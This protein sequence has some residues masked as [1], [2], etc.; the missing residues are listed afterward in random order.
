MA[1]SIF[2]Q[3][4][5]NNREKPAWHGLGI[6]D[7]N[8]HYAPELVAKFGSPEILK[9]P[10]MVTLPNGTVEATPYHSL[11]RAP[12]PDDNRWL[13]FGT[14]VSAD[15]EVFNATIAAR[16][17]DQYVRDTRG[18]RVPVETVALLQM[19]TR[20]FITV[21]LPTVDVRGD[22]VE[23][24]L[25]LDVPFG[26][27]ETIGCYVTPVRVVCMNTLRMG[28]A[29][30]QQ[31][32]RITHTKGAMEILGE[33]LSDV[34]LRALE[35]SGILKEALTVLATKP[36]TSDLQIKWFAEMVYPYP[37]KP[38]A[39]SPSARKP[40][41][42]RIERWET[43]C[44]RTDLIRAA[45]I[46]DGKWKGL[47]TPACAGTAF[48]VYQRAAEYET[49]GR[50]GNV[51]GMV[52]SLFNGN[53]GNTIMDAYVVASH[54]DKYDTATRFSMGLSSVALLEDGDE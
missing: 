19:G 40:L 23:M 33:W 49:W 38:Q 31:Y 50:R 39:D 11:Y 45:I 52:S 22:E 32:F 2:G 41:S 24:Y 51:A 3:R 13:Q 18:N 6:N 26:N 25:V 46:D 17:F 7:P 16:I 37:S 29:E 1:H 15:F 47:N 35:A 14:P 12:M 27:W 20:I 42:E 4:F 43:A 34:Y 28:I 21:K 44:E 30:A 48:G 36:V 8:A 10:L 9:L 53:R 54:I 5:Y